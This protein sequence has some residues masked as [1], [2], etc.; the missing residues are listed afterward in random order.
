MGQAKQKQQNREECQKLSRPMSQ[1]RF[2]IFAIG[3]RMSPTQYMSEEISYWSDLEERVLG[4]VFCD[5]TDSDYGWA[6]L[7]RDR[8]GRFRSVDLA[9]SLRSPEYATPSEKSG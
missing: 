1:A 5:I 9:V 3:T 8:L 7:A 4:L 6:L 2:N